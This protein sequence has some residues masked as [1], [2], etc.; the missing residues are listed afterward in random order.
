M[1]KICTPTAFD[2][3]NNIRKWRSLKNYNQKLFA[4][5]LDISI[6]ALCKIEN[7]KTDINLSRLCKISQILQVDIRQLFCDPVTLIL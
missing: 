4:D 1:E 7:G 5:Q 3:G 2:I 6:V